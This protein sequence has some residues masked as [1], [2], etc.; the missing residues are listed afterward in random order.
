MHVLCVRCV[1][2][3]FVCHVKGGTQG[4]GVLEWDVEE[5]VGVSEG[6][7]NRRLEEIA[8]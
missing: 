1:I 4:G 7:V 2:C 5:G 6:G 3:L 8:W